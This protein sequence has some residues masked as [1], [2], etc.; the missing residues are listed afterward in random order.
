MLNLLVFAVIG[1][2]AGAAGRL[3]YPGRRPLRI[4]GTMLIGMAGAL[5]GGALSWTYWPFVDGQ[6]QSGN[7]IVSLIGAMIMLVLSAGFTYLRRLKGYS[8]KSI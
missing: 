5:A 8:T 1:L 7:L 4:L 2:L 3:L 6:F